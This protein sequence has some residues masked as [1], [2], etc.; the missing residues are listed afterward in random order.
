MSCSHLYLFSSPRMIIC[1]SENLLA[2]TNCAEPTYEWTPGGA[3][4]EE[5]ALVPETTQEVEVTC[6]G[7]GVPA[8]DEICIPIIMPGC[9]YSTPSVPDAGIYF[10]CIVGTTDTLTGELFAED[11]EC[12]GD[13]IDWTT[14]E[15]DYTHVPTGLTCAYGGADRTI[16]ATV[17]FDL[18]RSGVY[19]VPTRVYSAAGIVSNW[20]LSRIVVGI[21]DAQTI[22]GDCCE[23]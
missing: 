2:D 21:T 23:P 13:A 8:T 1:Q 14:V 3:T 19:Y 18:V 10:E 15:F 17:D 20:S 9:G 4:T 11:Y 6:P 16:E 12:A 7:C 5:I 22:L